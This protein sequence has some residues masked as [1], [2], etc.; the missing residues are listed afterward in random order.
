MIFKRLIA[1]ACC[2]LF[3]LEAY[4]I[5]GDSL[6]TITALKN[7]YQF[8]WN[9]QTNR[10][11]IKEKLSN[12]YVSNTYG[13]SY[14]VSE[15]YND[16]T[17]IDAVSCKIDGHNLRSFKPTY[18]YYSQDDVFYSDAKICYFLMDMPK[19]GSIGTVTF[20]ET[21][22][23][24]RYFT[25]IYFSDAAIVQQGEVS[26]KIPRWMK[27]DI[28]EM[29][30]NS[31]GIKKTSEYIS[32]EDADVITYSFTNI[33]AMKREANSPGPTYIY[34]HLLVLCKS[35]APGGKQITYFGSLAD[36]YAWYREL[37]KNVAGDQAVIS[38]KAKELTA[39]LTADMDK[40]KAIFYYVQDNI[41][42]IAFEDGMAGFKPEKA[43]EVLRK[44][45]GDCKGMANLTKALLVSQ[46]YDAR[47][48]W[49]G[50]KHIAYDY[51]TPSM[52]VDNHMI[53]ALNYKGKIYYLDAT[54]SY[55]SLNEYAERIQGRQV[56]ME[57]GDK[58]VL[59][60]IPYASPL[61]NSTNQLSKLSVSGT[62]LVGKVNYTWK[63]ED[64]ESIL[65]GLNS[66]KHENTDKAMVKYLAD[67]NN[68]Y[69][70]NNLK[71]SST[72]NPDKD[73]TA[74]FDLE[75]KNAV[76]VFSK[77]YYINID[78]QKELADF[79]FKPAVRK[80]DYWFAY[81]MNI[82][83]QTELDIPANYKA[84]TIPADLNIVN[85][86]YE[87]HISYT[88]L[89]NKLVYK[90]SLLIKNTSLPKTRFEQWNHDVELLGKAYN[91]TLILKPTN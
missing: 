87:F 71:L 63:G 7:E 19:K 13:V 65:S 23:D 41:R 79:T 33:P 85:P 50:T 54:E 84:A 4:A 42:Y 3:A 64:K 66:I 27:V 32:G 16:N 5:E 74:A 57:D 37:V 30:F 81:K 49:L 58:Y 76:N 25:S 8:K 83:S 22:N 24:P 36:Q 31:F 14:P 1:Y 68:D 53:C 44:K 88:Q 9:G 40:I 60:K 20:E 34:P 21:L 86:D 10:V 75:H 43:D 70:I 61:Q 29:N 39:G 62:S 91:D 6:V 48:C 46:G 56:L 69:T 2:M 35:A 67:D 55:L 82:N 89:T 78:S 47:L 90:K 73:L 15:F 12:T 38:A 51:Q 18:T 52:A 72:A 80:L 26:L 11:E 77:D 28:K 45:Y 17:S 59:N